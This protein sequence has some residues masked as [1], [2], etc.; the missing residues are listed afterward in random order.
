MFPEC[1]GVY[2]AQKENELFLVKVR[3]IYPSLT[4][5]KHA[6][7]LG[8][9]LTSGKTKEV[10]QSVLDNMEIF[11][12]EW[13]F[14]PLDSRL[15]LNVF[16]KANIVPLGTKLEIS[17]EE[18]LNIAGKYRRM[19]Q[20][21][22]SPLKIIRALAYEFKTSTDQIIELVNKLDAQYFS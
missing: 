18:V 14:L 11:H 17:Y 20:Q 22:V 2:Y 1:S 5:D 6:I 12:T 16:S 13:D 15:N 8:A 9:Y 7:D 10:P 4:L 21:G 3:G 19:C